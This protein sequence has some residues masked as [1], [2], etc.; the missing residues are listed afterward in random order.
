MSGIIQPTGER[1]EPV[2]ER[3]PA[4]LAGLLYTPVRREV[5]E[6]ERLGPAITRA[7]LEVRGNRTPR[8]AADRLVPGPEM[9]GTGPLA[10]T[11]PVTAV[12]EAGLRLR[13]LER[14]VP[15]GSRGPEAEEEEQR[16]QPRALRAG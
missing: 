1:V 13:P 16:T 8:A 11:A 9:A 6:V 4:G 3:L 10:L 7:A 15:V 12:V 14:V 5:R 2:P